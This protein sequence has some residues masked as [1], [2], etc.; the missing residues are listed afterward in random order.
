ME[1][2]GRRPGLEA[3]GRRTPRASKRHASRFRRRGKRDGHAVQ[4][5]LQN[6]ERDV[7]I[8]RNAHLEVRSTLTQIAD[9][10][11]SCI[12]VARRSRQRLARPRFLR[13][14][15][16]R[17]ERQS[18]TLVGSREMKNV[19]ARKNPLCAKTRGSKPEANSIP[20]ASFLS[21]SFPS[22]ARLVCLPFLLRHYP[23]A[24]PSQTS[25]NIEELAAECAINRFLKTG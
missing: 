25:A 9:S 15:A 16:A 19:G 8:A 17:G 14:L 3:G 2:G 13:G 11:L 22:T 10:Q 20:Q 21:T 4:L 23:K 6:I 1:A 7:N 18:V 5:L 24:R 12:A